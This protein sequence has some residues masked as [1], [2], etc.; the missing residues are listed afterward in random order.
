[1]IIPTAR[2]HNPTLANPLSQF[3]T[4]TRVELRSFLA[5]NVERYLFGDLE[6]MGNL[7]DIPPPLGGGVGYPVLQSAFAGIEL[8]GGM[9]ASEPFSAEAKAGRSYFV[10]YWESYLYPNQAFAREIANAVYTLFRNG[11]AHTFLPKGAVGVYVGNAPMHLK[12][13][14]S[15]VVYLD[16]LQLASDLKKSYF[17][18]VLPVVGDPTD[19][20]GDWMASQLREM[21][22]LDG[23][24]M[25]A[26]RIGEIFPLATSSAGQ[27]GPTGVR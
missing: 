5:H 16:A 3:M 13:D 11:I 23:K 21:A 8:L 15:G 24:K 6:R 12:R 25:S 9:V 4:T 14:A 10:G 19:P 26:L 18:R 22:H 27:E 1:V 2:A 7:R 17:D 20:L